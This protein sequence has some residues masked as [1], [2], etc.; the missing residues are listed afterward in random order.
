MLTNAS[1]LL[2]FMVEPLNRKVCL[3]PMMDYTDRHFRYLMRLISK[4]MLL[5]TEMVHCGAVLHGNR[6]RLLQFDNFE[7]PLALQLGGN[8]PQAL[9][10][11]ARIAQDC[12]YSEVNLNVG[13]PSDRVKSGQFGA[14]L[15]ATPGLVGDC[16]AAMQ[17]AVDIPVTVKNRIGI[18]KHADYE[19]L[20]RFTKTVAGAGCKTF[21]VHARNAWLNGLSP[22]ENRNIPPLEYEKVYRLKR[23]FPELEVVINGGISEYEQIEENLSKVD[24]VMIGRKAYGDPYYWKDIDNRYFG[25]EKVTISRQL[26]VKQYS[27]YI[28]SQSGNDVYLKHMVRH[29][30][31][32]FNGQPGARAWRRFLSENMCKKNAGVE[33]VEQAMELM[34]L[35]KCA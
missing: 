29:L 19:F 1:W 35:E 34:N 31:N 3:A 15:M 14:C 11:A 5:Y 7:I 12:G 32:L 28:Q 17:A 30:L 27:T 4:N 20:Y 25:S 22:K 9:A 18:D 23:D 26:F 6:Y 2:R 24:G 10:L 16:I 21:I 8:D 13:C 33:I